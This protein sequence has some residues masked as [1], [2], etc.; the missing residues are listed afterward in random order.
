MKTFFQLRE[1]TSGKTLKVSRDIFEAAQQMMSEDKHY[2]TEIDPETHD[3][4]HPAVRK[5]VD[6]AMSHVKKAVAH[7]KKQGYKV[8]HKNEGGGAI[9]KQH[10]KPDVTVYG[11][12]EGDTSY[13]VHAGGAAHNDRVMNNSKHDL[14]HDSKMDKH[15][16]E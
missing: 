15:A 16:Y 8:N 12:D 3:I 10:S 6:G 11:N 9:G 14:K 5:H 1:E 7:A 13:T 2:G 4:D